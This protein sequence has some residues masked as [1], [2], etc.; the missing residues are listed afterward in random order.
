MER[1]ENEGVISAEKLESA[2]YTAP[3]TITI[4]GIL[5]LLMENIDES[6]EKRVISLGMGD[7]TAYSCFRTAHVAQDSVLDSL[8][9]Q[10]F[11]GYAPTVGLPQTRRAV[12]EYLSRDLPYKL[13]S[14][15]VFITSGCTQA[16]DVALAMLARPGANILLPR[17]G[18]PIYEL[19]ASFRHIEVRHFD[20]LPENGWEVDLDAV[21]ALADHNTVALVIINPGNP[22]GNVCSYQHLEKIAETARKLNIPVIADEVYGHLA[23][24]RNLFVPMGVFGETV[25][26]LTLGSL[27]KRW[28]VPGWRLGWFVTSD[29][30]GMFREPKIIERIKKYFDILGGPATFIQAAVPR[31]LEQTEEVYFKRTNYLLKQNSDICC[32]RIMEIP[33]ITCPHRPEGSMAVMVKLNLSLLEDISDDIDFCFKLAKEESVIFLPGTAVGLKNWLRITFAVDPSALE[34]ALRRTKS[35]YQRHAK[36]V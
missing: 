35:F 1:R 16:I 8:H 20:L 10:K 7:P 23:F 3:S 33:C 25:P 34:E 26:V 12:A 17:P 19:C 2:A 13:T 15:D 21:E 14:D 36:L 9:S 29:P 18:F 6:N 22:C 32:D 24:G 5:G 31:I 4:K 28:I 30:C 11:N 27:S